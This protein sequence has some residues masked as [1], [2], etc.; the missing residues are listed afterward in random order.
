LKKPARKT[1]RPNIKCN[2]KEPNSRLYGKPGENEEE[3]RWK[4]VD[5]VE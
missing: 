3:E 2:D 5:N 1:Q 4:K